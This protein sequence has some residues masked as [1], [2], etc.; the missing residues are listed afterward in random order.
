MGG[1]IALAN[2]PAWA[3]KYQLNS[4]F[5]EAYSALYNIWFRFT[6]LPLLAAI[7]TALSGKLVVL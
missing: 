2:H 7:Q 6:V 5:Y 1:T 4:S 3:T